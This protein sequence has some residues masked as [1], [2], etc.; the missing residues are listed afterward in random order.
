MFKSNLLEL[1]FCSRSVMMSNE[2]GEW[3]R[4]GEGGR[5]ER[6]GETINFPTLILLIAFPL[7]PANALCVFAQPMIN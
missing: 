1:S 4:E 2:G 6:E 3:G 5:G 7:S